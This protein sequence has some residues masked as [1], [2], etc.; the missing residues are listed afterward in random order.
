[1]ND[2]FSV[3]SDV[4]A[5]PVGGGQKPIAFPALGGPRPQIDNEDEQVSKKSPI[6]NFSA[7]G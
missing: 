6:S 1:M 7:S 2:Q 4:L 3:F 5:L